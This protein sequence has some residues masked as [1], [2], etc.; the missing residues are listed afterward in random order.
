MKIYLDNCCY[1]RPYDDQSQ[2]RISLETQA[3]LRIQEMVRNRE[4][5][6]V[7]SYILLFE[8]SKNPHDLKKNAI[9][10][11]ILANAEEYIDYDKSE[12]IKETA[13]RIISTGVKTVDAYHVA[14]AI[15]ADCDYFITTDDRLLKF[16]TPEIMICDPTQF[17]RLM[18]VT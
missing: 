8:N 1:N 16:S 2:L 17:I 13:N 14:S 7:A 6:L 9:Y 5:E 18:E 15:I 11:F 3:K 4:L 10:D 12:S